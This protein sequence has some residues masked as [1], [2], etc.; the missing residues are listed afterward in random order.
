MRRS[1]PSRFLAAVVV[2]AA[3]PLSHFMGQ[4][5]P[6]V[7]PR[8][9]VSGD[10]PL[11]KVAEYKMCEPRYSPGAVAD[12]NYIYIVGG[13]IGVGTASATVE[14][15]DLR[16]GKS[17]IFAK[18]R[19]PRLWHRAVMVEGKVYVLGGVE[20]GLSRTTAVQRPAPGT[21]PDL[22]ST[23][24]SLDLVET[25]EI[26]DVATGKVSD[27]PTLPDPRQQF[28]CVVV[29]GRIY[30]FGGKHKYR[31]QSSTTN[32]VQILDLKTG[33]WS[34][35]P[36]M[37]GSPRTADATLVDGGFVVVT[38]GYDGRQARSEVF[39]LDLR[40]HQWNAI[41]PLG[42]E[43]SAHA[44]VYQGQ[45]IFLFGDYAHPEQVLA[46]NLKT[47]ESDI[48][49]LGYTPARHTAVVTGGDG[50]FY[51]IGGRP[52]VYSGPLDLIQVFEPTKKRMPAIPAR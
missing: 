32:T 36:P 2:L 46:Y 43:T 31:G 8:M 30:L 34:D 50:R 41:K 29:G 25:I 13:L 48:F 9:K 52:D 22:F 37:P 18:L 15:F 39:A 10:V 12:G 21:W 51:I 26:V 49:T 6:Q 38:G 40:T 23:G 42:R 14:R 45:H 20:F 47:K 19:I 27:G 11:V 3:V 35:G 16:T 24:V 5:A 17:E 44:S 1:S 28:G 7:L 4:E 33:R